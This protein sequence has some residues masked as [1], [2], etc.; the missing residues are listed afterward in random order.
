M[1]TRVKWFLC[2][3]ICLLMCCSAACALTFETALQQAS[4]EPGPDHFTVA[5]PVEMERIR[6]DFPVGLS[7]SWTYEDDELTIL[8]DTEKTDWAKVL[9]QCYAAES[10]KAYLYPGFSAPGGVAM[11]QQGSGFSLDYSEKGLLDIYWRE[12]QMYGPINSSTVFQHS[13]EIGLYDQ[14]SRTFQPVPHG[15]LGIMCVWGEDGALYMDYMIVNINFTSTGPVA[16]PYPKVP[17]SNIYAL[18]D[19]YDEEQ[20][21]AVSTVKD[22]SVFLTWDTNAQFQQ[23][24]GEIAVAVPQEAGNEAWTCNWIGSWA[25]ERYECFMLDPQ[26]YGLERRSALVATVDLSVEERTYEHKVTLEWVDETGTVRSYETFALTVVCGSPKPWPAYIADWQPVDAS[27]LIIDARNFLPGMQAVYDVNGIV[28]VS[29]DP[30]KLPETADY[31]QALLDLFVKLPSPN[32]TIRGWTQSG[33]GS[34]IYGPA[35]SGNIE[36]TKRQLRDNAA[37]NELKSSV[38][39]LN[40]FRPYHQHGD[41]VTVYT[42]NGPKGDFAGQMVII[43][44]WQNWQNPQIDEPYLTEYVIIRIEDGVQTLSV[45]P[46]TDES[47]LPDVINEPMMV[48]P[49]NAQTPIDDLR[50]VTTIYPQKGENA[51]YYLLDLLDQTDA[52]V[53]VTWG[54]SKVFLPYPEEISDEEKNALQLLLLDGADQALEIF[55]VGSATLHLTEGGIWFYADAFGPYLLSWRNRDHAPKC[56]NGH[57][58]RYYSAVAGSGLAEVCSGGCHQ[59]FVLLGEGPDEFYIGDSLALLITREGEWQGTQPVAYY[60][61]I[62]DGMYGD[63]SSAEPSKAGEYA[64]SLRIGDLN[65]I[66]YNFSILKESILLEKIEAGAFAGTDVVQVVC[67]DGLMEIGSRAFANC[68]RLRRITIPASVSLIADDAFKGC[69]M[70]I[71]EGQSGSYAESFAQSIG[72]VFQIIDE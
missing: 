53:N 60:T 36:H 66:A 63:W 28:T 5:R 38:I 50:L 33:G 31:S 72:A 44:W 19:L 67:P 29:L 8:I 6:T 22:G 42:V 58:L 62:V 55:S 52:A 21:Q 32:C 41:D 20:G 12:Y 40:I 11:P 64:V 17:A 3:L 49:P 56:A 30:D 26:V 59:A 10:G 68:M 16:V 37:S 43:S 2:C 51:R 54:K 45:T 13:M 61:K 15:R 69:G 18:Y 46:R 27:R 35:T 57:L 25:G 34:N 7:A 1:Y 39:G 14:N 48:I 65:T 70:L 4:D 71:I 47:F 23:L 9:P 24:Q